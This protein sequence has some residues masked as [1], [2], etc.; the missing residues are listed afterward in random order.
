[1]NEIDTKQR[2]VL[3]VDA[4]VHVHTA[5]LARV[6][7]D[8]GAR[9]GHLQLLLVGR[10]RE[11]GARRHRNLREERAGGLPALRATAY[12]IVCALALYRNGHL[13]V[14]AFAI[15]R[16]SGEIG[17][18]GLQ[19]VIDLRMNRWCVGHVKSSVVEK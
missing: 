19:S 9:I 3:V 8:R 15:Q 2:M 16:A 4:P 1:M 11:V 10:D 18:G 13:L 7:L 14:G 12:V 5:L 17:G 6:A